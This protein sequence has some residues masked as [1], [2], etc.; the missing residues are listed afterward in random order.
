MKY[1]YFTFLVFCFAAY[2][3]II[4]QSVAKLFVYASNL[5]KYQYE[6]MK[7]WMLNNPANPVVKYL[8]WRR[9]MKLAKE[10]ENDLKTKKSTVSCEKHEDSL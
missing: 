9:A 6:K 1:Y 10:I 2:L 7:W 8:I 3:I 5:L 4:D